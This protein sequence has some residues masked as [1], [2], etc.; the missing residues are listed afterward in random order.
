MPRKKKDYIQLNMKVDRKVMEAF[1]K[2][3]EYAGQS[4]TVAFERMVYQYLSR[5]YGEDIFEGYGVDIFEEKSREN[6]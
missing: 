3:C 1:N 2:H 6:E 4:K 5:L